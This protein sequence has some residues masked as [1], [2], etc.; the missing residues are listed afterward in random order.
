M[1][2]KEYLWV[3]NYMDTNCGGC[4]KLS[5]VYQTLTKQKTLSG[6]KIKFGYVDVGE[7]TNKMILTT[8]CGTT[9]V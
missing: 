6:R 9:K 8:Y 5:E 3:I 7:V 4:K 1:D 2:D